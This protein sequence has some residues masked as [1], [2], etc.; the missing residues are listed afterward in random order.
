PSPIPVSQLSRER[1]GDRKSRAPK[2]DAIHRSI[3]SGLLGHIAQREER[4]LY[5]AARGREVMV[6]PGSS[7]SDRTDKK[8]C[9]TIPDQTAKVSQP[10]WIVAGEIVETSQLFARTLAQIDPAWIAELGSHVCKVSHTDPH[11]DREL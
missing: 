3:L 6:F 8:S 1:E 11:W 4:N 7:L 10:E 2:F 9:R 5:K